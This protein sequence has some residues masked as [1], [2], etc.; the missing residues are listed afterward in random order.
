MQAIFSVLGQ[1][2]SKSILAL[3]LVT[4]ISTASA[5]VLVQQP[6][7]ALTPDEKIDRAYEYSEATGLREEDRQ[8]DYL[9]EVGK[10]QQS[11]NVDKEYQE[12]T[13]AN[14]KEK[15]GFSIAEQAK[16]FIEKVTG[17]D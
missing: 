5:L 4:L 14:Q 11:N 2:F 9:E 8:K 13:K 1:A 3:C 12:N 16:G 6:S 17:K 10:A 15:P 7:Y